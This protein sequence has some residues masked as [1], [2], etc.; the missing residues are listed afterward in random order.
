[1][2]D[3]FKAIFKKSR[4]PQNHLHHLGS[5]FRYTKDFRLLECVP[6]GILGNSAQQIYPFLGQMDRV[7][8]YVG[9]EATTDQLLA[10][11]AKVRARAKTKTDERGLDLLEMLVR[12]RASEV[13]NQPGQHVPL[14]LDAMQRAFKLDW[15][16]GERRLMAD[17]LAGLGKI[18]QKPLADEQVRELEALFHAEKKAT[19][20]QLHIATRWA[21]TVRGYG[22]PGR[23]KSIDILEPALDAYVAAHGDK[24]GTDAQTAFDQLIGY[25]E[26][27]KTFA[28][29]ET[30]IFA[31][32]KRDV[33]ITVADWLELRKFRLYTKAIP[34][35]TG[36]VSLGEGTELYQN[37]TRKFLSALATKRNNHRYQLC[38][39]LIRM[40]RAAHDKAKITRVK[41]DIVTFGS[42]A[43]DEMIG[44]D[45]QNYQNLVRSLGD[46]IHDITGDLPA[47]AFLI[48]RYERE[49]ESFRA[50]GRSGW[51]RYGYYIARYRAR[52]KNIGNLEPRLLKIVLIELRRDLETQR[53]HQRNIY[54]NGN[55]YFWKEKRG[56]F[57]QLAEQV[58][59]ERKKSIVALR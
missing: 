56:D 9:D 11:L 5:L 27:D 59:R 18:T 43:F 28:R 52:A 39:Q 34:S 37:A 54:H 24:L 38:D 14:A 26:S 7:L 25:F 57:Q 16:T 15:G 49:P 17:F 53:S 36:R 2:I 20:D 58:A 30:K 6:E 47:L 48:E 23:G 12:R 41:K 10:H 35:K 29:G 3:M 32:L 22:G 13:L 46:A 50:S 8:R 19:P 40:Y 33:N 44:F 45:T 55:R 21:A 51:Q 1:V 42:G 4:H 31:A